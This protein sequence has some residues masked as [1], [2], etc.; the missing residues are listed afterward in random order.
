M[1]HKPHGVPSGAAVD[2]RV[3]DSSRS[4]AGTTLRKRQE[5]TSVSRNLWGQLCQDDLSVLEV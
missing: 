4:P 5:Q 3:E 1:V 2:I